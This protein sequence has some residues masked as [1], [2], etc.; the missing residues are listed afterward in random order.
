MSAFLSVSRRRSERSHFPTGANLCSASQRVKEANPEA[1]MPPNALLKPAS[2]L[3]REAY[4]AAGECSCVGWLNISIFCD[5]ALAYSIG[6]L[7][8]FNMNVSK[9]RRRSSQSIKFWAALSG[10]SLS[11]SQLPPFLHLAERS[12]WRPPK[13]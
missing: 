1:A 9:R 5:T 4:A 6:Q 11:F 12:R 8:I 7:K 13:R 10:L 2:A 3:S